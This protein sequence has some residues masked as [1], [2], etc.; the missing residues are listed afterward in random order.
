MQYSMVNDVLSVV[1]EDKL[2]TTDLSINKNTKLIFELI[3]DKKD[4][5][6]LINAIEQPDIDLYNI[7]KVEDIGFVIDES[8][9]KWKR[10]TLPRTTAD[11][12]IRLTQSNINTDYIKFFI[13]R[14]YT[15]VSKN[16]REQTHKFL[17]NHHLPIT[18][19]GLF[20]A[21]KSVTPDFKDW[22]TRS[23]DNSPGAMIPRLNRNEVDDNINIGC[24]HG[25]HVGSIGY[26]KS[27]HG[28]GVIM[29][30]LVD[31]ADIVCVP[32]DS[33]QKVRVTY[34]QP[35]KRIFDKLDAPAYS[36]N[37]DRLGEYEY[38]EGTFNWENYAE[39]W[40]DDRDN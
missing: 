7:K 17:Q 23:I 28:G 18:P 20:W 1:H 22:H 39:E 21:Y 31:P 9:V 27:F 32:N 10:W 6:L 29:A 35:V 14:L 5:P 38:A 2:Y 4:I 16:A 12:V 40:D 19:E 11:L 26:A 37:L 15:N 3:K 8:M 34:Y 24:S 25:Y 13:N 33:Y 30:C 36:K